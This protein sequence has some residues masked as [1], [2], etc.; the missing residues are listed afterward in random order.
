MEKGASEW[1]S[2]S[3]FSRARRRPELPTHTPYRTD[4]S[5]TWPTGRIGPRVVPR[6]CPGD[7]K[8]L[9]RAVPAS[10]Y[11]G[12]TH[13]SLPRANKIMAHNGIKFDTPDIEGPIRRYKAAF[14]GGLWI[15]RSQRKVILPKLQFCTCIQVFPL[16]TILG[17]V[18]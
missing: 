10:A 7:G 4:V 9:A 17:V 18:C 16:A 12:H 14:S 2:S 5:I 3:E 13:P 11:P 8:G 6:C 15:S 1:I